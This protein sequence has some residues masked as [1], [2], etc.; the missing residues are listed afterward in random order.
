MPNELCFVA[1]QGP[2]IDDEGADD[3]DDV[4]PGHGIDDGFFDDRNELD[5][6]GEKIPLP[7]LPRR[8]GHT[9]PRRGSVPAAFPMTPPEYGGPGIVNLTLVKVILLQVN[10]LS[11]R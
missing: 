6:R 4:V 3:G 8:N 2:E 7:E 11:F 10:F 9:P 5:G 1:L